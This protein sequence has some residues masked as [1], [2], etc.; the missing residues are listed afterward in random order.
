[1][2][3]SLSSQ[4]NNIKGK[5]QAATFREDPPKHASPWKRKRWG[6]KGSNDRKSRSGNEIL[7]SLGLSHRFSHAI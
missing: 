4:E 3:L 7:Q 2:L 1:M 6:I 5:T